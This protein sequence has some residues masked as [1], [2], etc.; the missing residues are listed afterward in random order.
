MRPRS[1][2][3]GFATKSEDPQV[4]TVVGGTISRLASSLQRNI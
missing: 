4:K 3:K 1:Q 2:T